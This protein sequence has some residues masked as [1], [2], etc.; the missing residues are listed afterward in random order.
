MTYN[1]IVNS[2][3]SLPK[4]ANEISEIIEE[5]KLN[6]ILLTG[7][8]GAGKTTL[9]KHLCGSMGVLDTVT[10]PTFAL[11]NEYSNPYGE[12]IYHFDIYRIDSIDEVIDLGYEEY[13]YSG[14][15]CFIEWWEKMAE[16]IPYSYE[17]GI[18]L[19]ELSIETT[20]P[21]TRKITLTIKTK[22]IA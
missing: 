2:L 11:I 9:I 12:P 10:S 15:L 22:S 18:N 21:T 16:L 20:S 3:D 1:F 6:I 14:A 8:M 7:A 19:A 13:I 17:P 5:H 4:I